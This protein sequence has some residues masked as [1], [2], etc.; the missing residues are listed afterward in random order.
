MT[1]PFAELSHDK[2]MLIL[3][4]HVLIPYGI[5]YEIQVNSTPPTFHLCI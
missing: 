3:I 5:I 1:K 2:H 4:P